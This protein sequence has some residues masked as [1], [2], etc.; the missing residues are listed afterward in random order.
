MGR[1]VRIGRVG[2]RVCAA[3]GRGGAA[4]CET[5]NLLATLAVGSSQERM[6]AVIEA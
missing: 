6:H 4:T 1:R 2:I 3:V 5:R